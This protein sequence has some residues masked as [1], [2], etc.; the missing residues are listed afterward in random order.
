MIV[1]EAF[2]S[3]PLGDQMVLRLCL[4]CGACSVVAAFC[5]ALWAAVEKKK[6]Q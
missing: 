4:C 1:V 2:K 5:G 3:L 6:D